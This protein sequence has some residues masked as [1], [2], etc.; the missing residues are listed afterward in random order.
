MNLSL[1]S[2]IVLV[3]FN[4]VWQIMLWCYDLLHPVL[5][6]MLVFFFPVFA[7]VAI[8]LITYEKIAESWVGPVIGSTVLFPILY[9][10]AYATRAPDYIE[11][12]HSGRDVF[13]GQ[14]AAI[15]NDEHKFYTLEDSLVKADEFGTAYHSNK[16]RQSTTTYSKYF[17][18]PVYDAGTGERRDV[19]ICSSVSKGLRID[20]GAGGPYGM[21]ETELKS[22]FGTG[23]IYGR[24]IV[25]SNCFRAVASYLEK[26]GLPPMERPLVIDLEK[27]TS[28]EYYRK[29]RIHFWIL[30]AALNAFFIIFFVFV[31]RANKGI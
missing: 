6:F 28:D 1:S 4:V 29:A 11:Y 20:D 9:C 24:K 30:T 31:Y 5:G 16:P 2:L 18:L 17:A 13:I 15:D 23:V 14:P 7:G 22:A 10:A 3:Y 12:I 8:Y 19:W 27:E 25:E 26:A 21:K